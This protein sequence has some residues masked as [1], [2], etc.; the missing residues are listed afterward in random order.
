[1]KKQTQISVRKRST[2]KALYETYIVWCNDNIRKAFVEKTFVTGL[3]SLSSKY[4]LIYIEKIK[5]DKDKYAVGF[6]GVYPRHF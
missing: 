1:M 3:K 5:I 6:R 2:C 4:G